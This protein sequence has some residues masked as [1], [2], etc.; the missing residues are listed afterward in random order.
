MP[1]HKPLYYFFLYSSYNDYQLLINYFAFL[2]KGRRGANGPSLPL[3]SL[4]TPDL[5]DA[6]LLLSACFFAGT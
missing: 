3:K 2:D 5:P 6:L 1:F 4:P